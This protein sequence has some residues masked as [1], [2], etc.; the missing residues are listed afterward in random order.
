[1]PR[2]KKKILK[3]GVIS[4][5]LKIKWLFTDHTTEEL[6]RDPLIDMSGVSHTKGEIVR[7]GDAN[8]KGVQFVQGVGYL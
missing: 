7:S 5:P 8:A 6:F 2:I 1:M 4:V 3:G